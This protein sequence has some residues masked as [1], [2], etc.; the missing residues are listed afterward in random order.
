MK[1]SSG[2]GVLKYWYTYAE[3]AFSYVMPSVF[4]SE[5]DEGKAPFLAPE[6]FDYPDW[7]YTWHDCDLIIRKLTKQDWALIIKYFKEVHDTEAGVFYRWPHKER[8]KDMCD[9]IYILLGAEYRK[10]KSKPY[11]AFNRVL[12]RLVG[13][14][15]EGEIDLSK[16]DPD[17][18]YTAKEVAD[19]LRY[20]TDT[21]T[22]L[23]REGK[24]KGGRAGDYGE[25][26]ILG[27]SI[28]DLLLGGGNENN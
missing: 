11:T 25:W 18:I 8:F 10:E 1:F 27:Q 13:R 16:V 2:V 21:I 7:W 26:R 9:R 6:H 20:H 12:A 19:L 15:K 4:I 22:Q 14:V 23:L 17:K 5:D 28:I 24:L 3:H